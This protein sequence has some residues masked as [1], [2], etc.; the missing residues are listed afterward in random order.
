MKTARR[1]ATSSGHLDSFALY[2]RD[3]SQRKP[4][5]NGE[6]RAF[7]AAIPKEDGSARKEA[8]QEFVERN[9]PFVIFR[10]RHFKT[11][12]DAVGFDFMDLV[13]EGNIGMLRAMERYDPSRGEF[14]T[15]AGRMIDQ[16]MR[17]A[18]MTFDGRAGV[19]MG[20]G[21]KQVAGSVARVL[22]SHKESG[23]GNLSPEE[24]HAAVIANMRERRRAKGR[25]DPDH[26][27]FPTQGAVAAALWALSRPVWRLDQPMPSS[28]GD[29][30][31]PFGSLIEDSETVSAETEVLARREIKR[32]EVF[33]REFFDRV[34]RRENDR[35]AD[36]IRK[37]FPLDD[38][39][40]PTFSTIGSEWK[41]G[42]E[43]VRQIEARV[44]LR[45]AHRD[46]RS[47]NAERLRFIELRR[48][49][50]VG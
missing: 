27:G 43:R 41:I 5:S 28:D 7:F 15:Y 11:W 48:L 21:V 49:L 2:T 38:E 10:A 18:L 39:E 44:V 25:R 17:R 23:G 30:S 33:F 36:I 50:G 13:S 6:A 35:N 37:R 31:A 19:H 40:R 47:F 22:R 12:A 24:V 14:T 1:S 26:G 9:Q 45:R 32:L 20:M 16:T 8:I 34:E 29:E 3:V 42:R 4:F 46:V